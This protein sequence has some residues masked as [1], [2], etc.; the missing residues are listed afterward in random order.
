MV[1]I[2]KDKHFVVPE[3]GK[4]LVRRVSGIVGVSTDYFGC[5]IKRHYDA[6]RNIHT[7]SFDCN[8]VDRITH[9]SIRPLP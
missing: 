7:N 1:D 9:V 3:D 2:T 6:K 4:Y 8:G 5:R